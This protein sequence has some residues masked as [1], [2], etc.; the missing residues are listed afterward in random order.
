MISSNRQF[1]RVIIRDREHRYLV[2]LRRYGSYYLWNFPG[3]KVET[4]ETPEQ[5]AYREVLEEI[6]LILPPI[7]LIWEQQFT[8]KRKKWLGF[9]FYTE[10]DNLNPVLMEPYLIKDIRYMT[11]SE[12]IEKQAI[13]E[14]FG[15]IAALIEARDPNFI[16]PSSIAQRTLR[17][18]N[19][20]SKY[21]HR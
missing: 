13:Q 19:D 10:T 9:F 16:W 14:I 17:I 18:W 15:N 21:I 6:G 7:S 11:Y 3:G 1:V 12:L 8:I 5:T 20:Y 4:G 2:L